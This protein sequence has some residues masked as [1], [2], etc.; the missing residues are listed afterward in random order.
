MSTEKEKKESFVKRQKDKAVGYGKKV[1]NA[2]EIKTNWEYIGGLWKGLLPK[3]LKKGREET[4]SNAYQRLSLTEDDLKK[5]YMFY[6]LRFYVFY[7]FG[8]VVFSI[9]LYSAYNQNW[10]TTM[11]C[12]G[13]IAVCFSFAFQ[14]SFRTMQIRMRQ[15][16][17]IDYWVKSPN[18]WFPPLSLDN[19]DNPPSSP[20]NSDKKDLM[21]KNSKTNIRVKY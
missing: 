2:E 11:S 8:I 6:V 15:L 7:I 5:A 4:F 20:G 13:F 12:F 16:A 9:M 3:K 17:G 14:A 1:V 21:V 18:Y 19:I 10:L